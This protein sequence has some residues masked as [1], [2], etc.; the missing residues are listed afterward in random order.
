MQNYPVP[1]RMT[2]FIIHMDEEFTNRIVHIST[3]D[4]TSKEPFVNYHFNYWLLTHTFNVTWTI[5]FCKTEISIQKE[6]D[7]TVRF[8]GMTFCHPDNSIGNRITQQTRRK[9]ERQKLKSE[10][11]SQ[12]R[13]NQIN[14]KK[15]FAN[16]SPGINTVK[17]FVWCCVLNIL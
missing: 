3:V 6:W 10:S 8:R 16:Y 14:Y 5:S 12:W 11:N 2:K 15:E 17:T 4:T 7:H 1:P 9:K 13:H